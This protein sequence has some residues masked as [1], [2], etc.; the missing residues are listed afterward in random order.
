MA[1]TATQDLA[2]SSVSLA[3]TIARAGRFV[4]A[5]AAF[6]ALDG[7]RAAVRAA[8]PERFDVIVIGGGQAGLSV[9][10]HLRRA[11]LRYVILD[12]QRHIGDTWRA[13]WDSLRLFTPARFCSLD[14]M[15][16]P[17]PWSYFPTKD[18]MADYLQAYADRFSIPVRSG[19]RVDAVRREGNRYVVEAGSACFEAPHVV[20]AAASYQKP[21]A[22][23]YAAQMSDT[24]RQ[25]QSVEYRNPAQLKP[26]SVLLVGAGNS[27]AEIAMDLAKT[28]EVIISGRHPGEIPVR[29]H[30]AFATKIVAPILFRLVFHRLLTVDTKPGRKVKPTFIAHGGPLIRVKSRDLAAA[31]VARV[32]RVTGAQEG[33]PL[34]ADGRAL[35]VDNIV[36]CTGFRHGLDWVKLPIFDADGRPRQYRGVVEGETGLYVV[37]LSFLHSMSSTMIHGV[38][39][40]ARRVVQAITARL[41]AAIAA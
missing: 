27:G 6:G 41:R 17:A 29:T 4:E 33:R 20:I 24:I 37:G 8:R 13:R 3:E 25:I 30:T 11:G 9:G 15:R 36:W 28:H 16:F 7:D 19:V 35:A 39:R 5:G 40:D 18:E 26:G 31:G 12:A 2:G 14:G 22:P 38:G 10:Y 23:D 21:K 32:P 1:A 34:L